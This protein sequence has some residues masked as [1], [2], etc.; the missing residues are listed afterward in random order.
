MEN[1][2]KNIENVK[3]IDN[4]TYIL[5]ILKTEIIACHYDNFLIRYLG[6]KKMQKF[7][8][9]KYYWDIHKANGEK[10]VNKS[11]IYMRSKLAHHKPYRNLQ[12]L[13]ICLYN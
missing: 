7:L 5:F 2:Q 11:K 1:P 4:K 3:Y 12:F 8:F 10:Y 13:S 6:I 9:H